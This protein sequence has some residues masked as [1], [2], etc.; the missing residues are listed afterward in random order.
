MK[1]KIPDSSASKDGGKVYGGKAKKRPP[2]VGSL[3]LS[4]FQ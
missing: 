2:G 1:L 3:S 4:I